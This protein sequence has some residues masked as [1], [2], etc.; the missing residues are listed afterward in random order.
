MS[1]RKRYVVNHFHTLQYTTLQSKN[2]IESTYNIYECFSHK[3]K[4]W[5]MEN[6]FHI[7]LFY[8]RA[9]RNPSSTFDK[10]LFYR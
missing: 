8:I 2:E 5:I 9:I 1:F 3:F 6:L 10:N 4:F 7:L